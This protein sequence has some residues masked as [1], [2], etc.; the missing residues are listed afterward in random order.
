MDYGGGECIPQEMSAHNPPGHH[1]GSHFQ[2]VTG[3]KV[4]T[5]KSC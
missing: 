4:T 3:Q 2:H 1:T 5:N